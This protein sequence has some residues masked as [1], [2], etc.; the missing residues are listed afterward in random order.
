MTSAVDSENKP[1]CLQ[2]YLNILWA[3]QGKGFF[4][5]FFHNKNAVKHATMM[6]DLVVGILFRIDVLRLCNE[7]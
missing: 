1:L 3:V 7:Q 6:L 5:H 2:A 4:H